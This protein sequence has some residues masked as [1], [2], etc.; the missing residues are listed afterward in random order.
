MKRKNL[1]IISVLVAVFILRLILCELA[2]HTMPETERIDISEL[3]LKENLSDEDYKVLLKQTGLGK[4]AVL[5]IKSSSDT[6]KEDILKYQEQNF[7]K[8]DYKCEYLFP[9]SNE[10]VLVTPDGESKTIM[11][12]PVKNGDILITKA[13]HTLGFRH[14]HSAIV[15]DAKNEITLESVVLGTKS[16]EQELDKWTKYPSLLI[17]RH[18]NDKIAQ[19]A[20]QFAK[21]NL[22][23]VDYGLFAGILKKDKQH[24]KK[25]DSTQCAHLV[26][27]A[28]YAAGEDVDKS[29]WLVIPDD[30]AQNKSL[31][32][33]FSYGF[34][35]ITRR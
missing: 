34:N 14:G 16:A 15:L 21:E 12:P 35:P 19:S 5:D 11:L 24:M 29:G 28:Y 10:E 32:I 25:I 1:I 3:L 23:N 4:S 6:F 18:K 31:E 30:I 9:V 17:L 13:T 26:W 22:I 2:A 7:E 27:Q 20:V 8:V 33:V